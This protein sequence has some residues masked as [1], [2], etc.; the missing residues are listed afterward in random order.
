MKQLFTTMMLG[1][2]LFGGAVNAQRIV[3]IPNQPSDPV[4]IVPFVENDTLADGSHDL[5][6]IYQLENGGVYLF[7]SR[8]SNP[9]WPLR[10]HAKDL[11]NT[12]LKPFILRFPNDDGSFPGNIRPEGDVELVNLWMTWGEGA[13]GANHSWGIF[14]VSADSLRIS[15]KDCIMEKDRGG[16]PQLRA[17]GTKIFIENTIFRSLGN[18]KILQGNGRGVDGRN[19]WIDSLVVKNSV[20]HNLQDRV[21]RSQGA[22]IPH[23]YIEYDQNTIFNQMGRHGAF[24]FGFGAKTVKITNNI[25]ENPT[26][27]G[28]TP[29]FNDEQFQVDN[30]NKFVF[31]IDGDQNRVDSIGTTFT[32]DNNNIYWTKDVLDYYAT[33][34]TVSQIGIFSQEVARKIGAGIDTAYFSEVL[35]FSN[36]PVRLTPYLIDAY[37]D[38][39]STEMF[40]LIVEPNSAADAFPDVFGDYENLYDFQSF[41]IGYSTESASFTAATDGGSIGARFGNF[42]LPVDDVLSMNDGLIETILVYPNPSQGAITFRYQL[43]RMEEVSMT[44]IDINGREITVLDSGMKASGSHEVQ[45]DLSKY[46]S[47]YG[48]YFATFKSSSKSQTMRLVYINQ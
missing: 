4:D 18:R 15:I 46:I 6:T 30:D 10:L 14:R 27:F 45:V 25:I 13:P 21:F 22:T 41:D 5:N 3:D 36:V 17:N 43:E 29:V 33:N 19:F 2:L 23:N 24:Q 11:E 32:F 42:G 31:T 20:F 38:P 9:G 28:M 8:L 35:E 26:M 39:A 12:A 34:D 47:D 48:V 40:D 7:Q 37:A 16:I 1:A 44:L